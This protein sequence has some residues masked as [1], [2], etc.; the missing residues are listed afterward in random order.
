MDFIKLYASNKNESDRGS[1]AFDI[2][3]EFGVDKWGFVSL[4]KREKTKVG[5]IRINKMKI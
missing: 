5:N 4:K 2:C 3:M 1:K